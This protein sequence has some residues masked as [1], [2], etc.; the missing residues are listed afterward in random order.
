MNR[1]AAHP[2]EVLR[3]EFVF[4]LELDAK[5]LGSALRLPVARVGAIMAEK[6]SV[7]ADSALRLARYF[8]TT[9]GFWMNLQVAHDLSK[10]EAEV[11]A[12]IEND[13]RPRADG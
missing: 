7:T 12:K 3:E 2:G 6:R 1:I 10:V 11:G 13:I 4:P 9:A 5:A 8:G